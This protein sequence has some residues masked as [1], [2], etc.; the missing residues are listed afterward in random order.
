MIRLLALA[1]LLSGC[2]AP[3]SQVPPTGMPASVPAPQIRVGDS[4]TYQ[5]RDG[6]TGIPRENQRNEV[7]KVGSEA[8]EVAGM[9]ERGDG[10]QVYDRAWN[11]LKRPAT[12]LQTFEYRPAYQAFA[13]PLAAGK[14][15]HERLTATDPAD[16]RQFPVWIDGIVRGW[17][18]VK[19]P[20]GDFDA[21]KVERMVY[22]E[23]WEYTVR[24]RSEIQ[25]VEWYAPAA[26][27]S[28][29]R[30]MRS[31]YYSLLASNEHG[32]PGFLQVKGGRNKGGDRNRGLVRARGGKDDGGPRYVQDDW[33]I[34]ELASYSVH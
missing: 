17:E 5:V 7:I 12:N 32:A 27:Q 30:E 25:E 8:V 29:K 24:G 4:W 6:F 2:A 16:G 10:L 31:R 20:A 9:T 3:L 34:Y 15:W 22:F 19:V 26:K 18:R 33:L 11:W 21:L 13:F 23:Y 14:R 28:V 1:A